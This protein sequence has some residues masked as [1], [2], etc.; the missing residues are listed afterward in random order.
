MSDLS[1]PLRDPE[2][3]IVILTPIELR[4]KAPYRL[5]EIAPDGEEMTHI[6]A[7]LQELRRPPLA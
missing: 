3:E 1:S 6:R 2:H 5:D 7:S 4:A